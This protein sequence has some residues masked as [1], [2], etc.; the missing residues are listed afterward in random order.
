MDASLRCNPLV[1]PAQPQ[2]SVCSRSVA[3]W[4]D[5]LGDCRR[6]LKLQV[7]IKRPLIRECLPAVRALVRAVQLDPNVRDSSIAGL[8]GSTDLHR[9]RHLPTRTD[10]SRMQNS[11]DA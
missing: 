5:M 10:Q 1:K 8:G 6:A 3:D 7:K 2:K 9:L 11:Y 4:V